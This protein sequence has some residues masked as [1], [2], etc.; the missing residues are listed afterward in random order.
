MVF[1]V[2]KKRLG[3]AEGRLRIIRES[4]PELGRLRL[5]LLL[6][7][8][9]PILFLV[10]VSRGSALVRSGSL[11]ATLIAIASIAGGIVATYYPETHD[12]LI[13]ASVGMAALGSWALCG[14]IAS[15]F[16]MAIWEG[17]LSKVEKLLL[18]S[19]RNRVDMARVCQG[20]ADDSER[21]GRIEDFNFFSCMRDRIAELQKD[22]H[23]DTARLSKTIAMLRSEMA[24]TNE[25]V[26]ADCFVRNF[27][28]TMIMFIG[29]VF[30]FAL[31]A[32]VMSG[33]PKA[34]DPDES[35]DFITGLYFSFTTV[36]TTDYG[37]IC[38]ARHLTRAIAVWEQC[39]GVAFMTVVIGMLMS[40]ARQNESVPLP[41]DRREDR[42]RRRIMAFTLSIYRDFKELSGPRR[43]IDELLD[44]VELRNR[45]IEHQKH[46]ASGF[47]R[48]N[49]KGKASGGDAPP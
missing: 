11:S 24:T 29:T 49:G 26:K 23:E 43:E 8:N 35:F 2:L 45:R 5:L 13:W 34:F 6:V 16:S 14:V 32:Q 25:I 27:S 47:L 19:R 28:S 30:A 10:L 17:F 20:Y 33:L 31:L 39:F 7:S 42:M 36:T 12:F 38:P 22:E 1:N 41:Q 15:A 44:E 40:M 48:Q 4:Y 9:W 18:G 46:G 37:D 3:E 21:E